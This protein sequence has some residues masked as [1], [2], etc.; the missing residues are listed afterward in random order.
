L[1]ADAQVRLEDQSLLENNWQFFR[2]ATLVGAH[3]S[4]GAF[5]VWM[6]WPHVVNGRQKEIAATRLI[7][8][9]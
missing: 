2:D 4:P 9:R 7:A 3:Y 5:D 1:K 6:G 8:A